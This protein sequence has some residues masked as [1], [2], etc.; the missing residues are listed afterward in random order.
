FDGLELVPPV[1][2]EPAHWWAG[3]RSHFDQV[4]PL[5]AGDPLGS[6]KAQHTQLVL[7]IVDQTHLGSPDLLV[8][9]EL[10]KRDELLLQTGSVSLVS[11]QFEMKKTDGRPGPSASSDLSRTAILTSPA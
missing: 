1:V 3:L 7:L 11:P 6:L 9:L 5:L 10:F 2:E 4:E 8:D